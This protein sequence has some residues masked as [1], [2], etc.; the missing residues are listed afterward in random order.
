MQE[1][2]DLHIHTKFSDGARM[3]EDIFVRIDNIGLKA[4]SITDHDTVD[5]C[6]AANAVKDKYKAEFLPGIELSC[7][8][9][10]K[11]YHLLG[12]NIDI[13]NDRLR[14]HLENFKNA[15]KY[16]AKR[17]I[18]KLKKAKLELDLDYILDIAGA[19]PIARPHIAA[20]MTNMNFV[21]NSKE[22]FLLYLGDGRPAYVEKSNFPIAD[23]IKLINQ[24]G[25]IASL[26][27]PGRSITQDALYKVIDLGLDAIEVIHPTHDEYLKK[28]YHT[29]AGQY[30]LLETGGSDYHGNREFDEFH[31]G[32]F[33][34]PYSVVESIKYHSS[35]K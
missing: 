9:K 25:G 22:A 13:N 3:P 27:H 12:Y 24:A 23:A 15:R 1:L 5:G 34:V 10:N 31:I 30:W 29:T 26:A 11:E 14:T 35:K 17:I 33:T 8:Y 18:E 32:K 28:H 4:F 20:A 2:A 19:A 16:R 21:T 6:I 7:H